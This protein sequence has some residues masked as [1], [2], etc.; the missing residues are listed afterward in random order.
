MFFF[1]NV[2]SEELLALRGCVVGRNALHLLFLYEFILSFQ[3]PLLDLLSLSLSV[4][5]SICPSVRP[6]VCH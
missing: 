1:E 3:H 5:L 2:A 6:S 4:R